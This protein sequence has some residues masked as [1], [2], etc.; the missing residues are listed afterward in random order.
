LHGLSLKSAKIWLHE[1]P[2][3]ASF[4]RTRWLNA[5]RLLLARLLRLT[6][7]R[8]GGW[9]DF[10]PNENNLYEVAECGAY[11][12]E[13]GFVVRA[14]P[15]FNQPTFVLNWHRLLGGATVSN[16]RHC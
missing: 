4:I 10:P 13:G 15:C 9:Q 16:P 7:A 2:R 6:N 8:S 14:M 1:I 3:Y 5:T 12:C 11:E